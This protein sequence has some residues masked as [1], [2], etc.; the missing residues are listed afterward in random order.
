MAKTFEIPELPGYRFPWYGRMPLDLWRVL[1]Q[2][3]YERDEGKC[4]Y[5]GE[6][7]ELY[8]CHCHHVLDLQH[9]GTNHPSNLKT[10]CRVCHKKRHPF[11]LDPLQRICGEGAVG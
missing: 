2:Y 5:C 8:D 9:G 6:H 7:T 10:L 11:M 4:R 1:R 3:V